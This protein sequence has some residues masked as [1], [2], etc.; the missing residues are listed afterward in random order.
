MPRRYTQTARPC[1]ILNPLSIARRAC[2]ASTAILLIVSACS[3]RTGYVRVAVP[4]GH[5]SGITKAQREKARGKV[6]KSL[7]SLT[8]GGVQEGFA[9]REA[10]SAALRGGGRELPSA[11]PQPSPSPAAAGAGDAFAP[12]PTAAQSPTLPNPYAATAFQRTLGEQIDDAMHIENELIEAEL[13]YAGDA[14]YLGPRARVYLI[15]FDIGLFP[16]RQNYFKYLPLYLRYGNAFN[17]TEDWFAQVEFRLPELREDA[18]ES[19]KLARPETVDEETMI[20]PPPSD[21]PAMFVY[22]VDPRYDVLT[23]NESL[24]MDRSF[25]LAAMYATPE[26][27]FQADYARRLEEL[28]A[29]YR[30]YPL[31][32]GF[33]EGSYRFSWSF[34]PRRQIKER[35]AWAYLN[36]FLGSYSVTQRLEPGSRHVQAVVVVPDVDKIA[37]TDFRCFP[38]ELL[39]PI[40]FHGGSQRLD[41]DYTW[42]RVKAASER[43]TSGDLT[44][45]ILVRATYVE[46]DRPDLGYPIGVNGERLFDVV[47]VRLPLDRDPP[48]LTGTFLTVAAGAANRSSLLARVDVLGADFSQS[49]PIAVTIRDLTQGT[50]LSVLDFQKASGK[51]LDVRF[52]R[53]GKPQNS[54]LKAIEL[55][56]FVR[57]K[58]SEYRPDLIEGTFLY[59][60][61]MGWRTPIVPPSR[62]TS[63]VSQP[64]SGHP[65]QLIVVTP[66]ADLLPPG[67]DSEARIADFVTSRLLS[68]RFGS[69]AIA[70]ADVV[71]LPESRAIGFIVPDLPGRGQGH[72]VDIIVT[73]KEVVAGKEKL[74]NR[75]I[76]TFTYASTP[77]K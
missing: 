27:T 33:V 23:A 28:F 77:T 1:S 52:A 44:L 76:G 69:L 16:Q 34:G 75:R 20:A 8:A 4:H 29:Q 32:L 61:A 5:A 15:R 13:L 10:I 11:E 66:G 62:D 17:F 36:P 73:L 56:A 51:A 18:C 6:A 2:A 59:D 9:A 67:K 50:D 71:Q 40:N 21:P 65:G 37:E 14:S 53:P 41:K 47:V 38:N 58:E 55:G 46:L 43:N 42:A 19:N 25:S 12:L 30:R 39:Q 64:T 48:A 57:T 54:D 7:E 45:P 24:A 26:A 22:D 60:E 63:L 70:K 31:Q 49:A 3:V 74:S 68:I 72:T 35:S